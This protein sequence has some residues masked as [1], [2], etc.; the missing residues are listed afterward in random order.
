[1]SVQPLLESVPEHPT[2]LPAALSVP[3]H[4]YSP[5]PGA[6]SNLQHLARSLVICRLSSPLRMQLP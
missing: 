6:S 4:Q 2:R 1:M 5:Q 3:L